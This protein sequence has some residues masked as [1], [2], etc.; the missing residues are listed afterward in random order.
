M[1]N[2]KRSLVSLVMAACLLPVFAQQ[3]SVKATMDSTAMFIGQ[4]SMMHLEISGPSSLKYSF[5]VF[6]GD[7]L[8]NGIEIVSTGPLDTLDR[9]NNQIYLK[10]DYLITS[11]DS[12]LYYIPPIKIIAG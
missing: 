10:R 12:G 8:V 2:Y 7:T 9:S 5:P 6:P 11:F 4:Q 1:L 3:V